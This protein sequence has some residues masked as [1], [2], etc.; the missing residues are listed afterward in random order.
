MDTA[1]S[2][3]DVVSV[4]MMQRVQRKRQV[5]IEIKKYENIN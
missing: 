5:L 1:E 4:V 2:K 3:R